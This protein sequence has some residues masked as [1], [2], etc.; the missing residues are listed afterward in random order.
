M[1]RRYASAL[2]GLGLA[3][4]SAVGP[5]PAPSPVIPEPQTAAPATELPV[6]EI[7]S[8]STPTPAPFNLAT[9]A[10][11]IEHSAEAGVPTVTPPGV[12]LPPAQL[13]IFRP[14][15]TSQLVSPFQV[16][17]RGG[18]SYNERVSIRLYG[19]DG[20]LISDQVTYLLVYPG[21]AGNFVARVEFDTPY[22]AEAARLEVSTQDPR[23]GRLAQ[24][25]SVD[26][27]LLST[28]TPRV[29]PQL[30][31]PEKLAILS[32]QEGALIQGGVVQV[33]GA[34]WAASDQPLT[35]ELLDRNG[36]PLARQAIWFDSA[37]IGQAGSFSVDLSYQIPFAQ[38][39]RLALF[40]QS[41][42]IPGTLHFSSVEIWLQP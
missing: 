12:G 8:E 13:T 31:G 21:R 37:V 32:P 42:G 11:V 28:G 14:G 25:A 20:R 7:P 17:G 35:I 38:Y 30:D 34:G 23:Y 41:V 18:P 10:I 15:P 16:F 2:I 22:V 5:L 24:L 29:H 40:E 27:V 3:A 6:V 33:R 4:C 26:L 1:R 39:A 19:E 9:P 36:S